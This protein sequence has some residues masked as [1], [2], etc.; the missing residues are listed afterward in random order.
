MKNKH[1]ER[2]QCIQ[3]YFGGKVIRWEYCIC[4]QKP[5]STRVQNEETTSGPGGFLKCNFLLRRKSTDTTCDLQLNV[6]WTWTERTGNNMSNWGNIEF[7]VQVEQGGTR[8]IPKLLK[9]DQFTG[10]Y[11]GVREKKGKV[12][13]ELKNIHN[14]KIFRYMAKNV[15]ARNN[16]KTHTQKG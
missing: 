8:D 7:E 16:K 5:I 13:A 14:K 12:G 9:R 2:K 6:N 15:A 1:F 10:V 3:K 11:I 4:K